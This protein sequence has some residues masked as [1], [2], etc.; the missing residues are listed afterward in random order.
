MPIKAQNSLDAPR[1]QTL[2]AT[3]VPRVTAPTP[4]DAAPDTAFEANRLRKPSMPIVT[5]IIT[6]TNPA[7][8]GGKKGRSGRKSRETVIS[9]RPAKSV[10]P[11]MSGSPPAC[12]A[13]TA[14]GR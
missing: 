2:S 11:N 8:S 14:A 13:S 7:I 6:T 5:P 12:R 4:Y 9:T 10:M 3:M 1:V